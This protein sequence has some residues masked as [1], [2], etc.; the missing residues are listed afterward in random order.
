MYHSGAAFP[1]EVDCA[2]VW[3]AHLS[4]DREGFRLRQVHSAEAHSLNYGLKPLLPL[5]PSV[6]RSGAAL[7]D[8]V[9]CAG[10]SQAHL[11]RDR[12][13]YVVTSVSVTYQNTLK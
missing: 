4:H 7:S 5:H 6:Y 8:E 1:D 11:S 2:G 10:V 13:G 12:V 9:H 3:Q